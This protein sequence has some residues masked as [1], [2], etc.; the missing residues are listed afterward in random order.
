MRK[1]VSGAR[2]WKSLCPRADNS[3]RPIPAGAY[4]RALQSR[5]RPI[6]V[7]QS[8]LLSSPH[9]PS[10]FC[11]SSCIS[12]AV[13]VV[14]RSMPQQDRPRPKSWTR[15]S[16][17]SATCARHFVLSNTRELPPDGILEAE[18]SRPGRLLNVRPR[19]K[20]LLY[21]TLACVSNDARSVIHRSTLHAH[22]G[23]TSC[24]PRVEK[25]DFP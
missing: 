14:L 22:H 23:R 11:S 5:R 16:G 4:R 15:R 8:Y 1:G 6:R 24:R 9:V 25:V 19:L 20:S 17:N 21:G 12:R 13:A 10:P 2:C 18:S 3:D 7:H